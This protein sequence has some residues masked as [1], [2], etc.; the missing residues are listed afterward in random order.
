MRLARCGVL[1]L[2]LLAGCAAKKPQ[3]PANPYLERAS[4]A[5]AAGV[6]ELALRHWDLADAAFRQALDAAVLADDRTWIARARFGIGA[7][8]LRRHQWQAAE[9]A[10]AQAIQEAARAENA[11]LMARAQAYRALARAHAHK[12]VQPPPLERVHVPDA[13]LAWGEALRVA[14][15][16][17]QAQRWFASLRRAAPVLVAEARLGAALCAEALGRVDEARTL[18]HKARELARKAAAP[19]IIAD[20][21]WL[22]A[23]VQRGKKALQQATDAYAIYRRL[24][25]PARMRKVRARIEE[26]ARAG[27]PEAKAWLRRHPKEHTR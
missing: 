7:V 4:L 5:Y 3:A 10:F 27:V 16:C 24:H 14:G 22:L 6:R 15:R 20:A 1:A 23:R 25:M 9:A 19:R 13:R 8:R 12:P 17:D 2:I 18:A 11:V 26:L 21:A